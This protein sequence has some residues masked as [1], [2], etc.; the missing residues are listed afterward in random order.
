MFTPG[1]SMYGKA[2]KKSARKTLKSSPWAH[3]H[4]IPLIH[5]RIG[6]ETLV[7]GVPIENTMDM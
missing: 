5:T 4:L 1:K 3:Y 6:P 7:S 2:A